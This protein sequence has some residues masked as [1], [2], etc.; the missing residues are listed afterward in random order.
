MVDKGPSCGYAAWNGR[1][2]AQAL[3]DVSKGQAWR[4]LSTPQDSTSKR[5][6]QVYFHRSGL[7]AKGAILQGPALVLLK[8]LRSSLSMKT[9]DTNHWKERRVIPKLPNVRA[10]FGQSQGYK[11]HGAT[12]LFAGAHS[13]RPGADFNRHCQAN[14]DTSEL[15]FIYSAGIDHWDF[16][17][18]PLTIVTLELSSITQKERLV[19]IYRSFH[20]PRRR[21]RYWRYNLLRR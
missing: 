11:R 15:C 14:L 1:L 2:V 5:A 20:W 8:M 21:Y 10:S 9:P 19:I 16:F 4:I 17:R 12:T 3:G 7:A 13:H 18:L 6:N